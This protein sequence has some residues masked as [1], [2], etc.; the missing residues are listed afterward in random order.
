MAHGS[1][2]LPERAGRVGTFSRFIFIGADLLR[3]F[4]DDTVQELSDRLNLIDFQRLDRGLEIA[5]NILAGAEPQ[6][7]TQSLLAAQDST[8]LLSLY[9]A[10]CTVDY[11]KSPERLSK[12]FNYVFEQVQTRKILRIAD[13]LPAMVRFLFD[14]DIIRLRFARLAW[15]KMPSEQVLTA[16]IFEWV[17][18]SAL[19][20]AIFQVAQP[21][22]HYDHIKRF[23][24]AFLLL[25]DKMDEDLITHSLRGMEI[26]PD[27]YHL[28]LQHLACNS[29]EILQ[30]V[31]ETLRALL[32]KS[33][34]SFWA[35]LGTISLATVAEQIFQS[36]TF[37][38]LLSKITLGDPQSSYILSWAPEFVQS[39]PSV[40]QYD[41]C[42]SLLYHLLER[43]QDRR[44]P[45]NARLACCHA[46]LD[47]LRATLVA[48][49]KSDY[50]INPSTSL[51]VIGDIL[52]LVDKYK[53][54]I[55][56]C[57]DLQN[58][59]PNHLGLK[60]LGMV[61]IRDALALDCKAL[62]AE[63]F[64]L[65]K[66][67][68]IQRGTT[69]HSESIWSAVLDVFRPGN[70]DL[71]KSILAAMSP[72]TGLDKL[73]P[74]DKKKPQHL[75]KSHAQFNQDLHKFSG[76]VSRVFERLSDFKSS[77]LWQLTEDSHAVRPFF[78]SLLSSDQET[79]E[80]AVEVM[81]AM[82]GHISKQEAFSDLLEKSFSPMLNSFTYAVT[83][84]IKTRTF[85]PTPYM[86]KIGRDVLKALTGNTGHLRNHSSLGNVDQNALMAWWLYQWRALDM[87]FS[88]TERWTARV[89]YPTN[90]FQDFCRD[91]ME[92]A[93]ELFDQ[94]EI[95]ASALREQTPTDEEKP[96]RSG[97]SKASMRKVLQVVCNHVN[98]LTMMIRLRDSYLI[99][100][101][102][103]LLGKLLRCLTQFD[104]EIDEFASTYIMDACK[105]ENEPGFRRTNLTRQQK[106]ELQ[107]ALFQHQGV[108]ILE[109]PPPVAKKQATIDA[110]SR[111]GDGKTHE[112]IA[113]I[114]NKGVAFLDNYF[115]SS[116]DK[117]SSGK[118]SSSSSAKSSAGMSNLDAWSKSA[119]SRKHEPKSAVKN[120][121]GGNLIDQQSI[122]D[123]MRA[124][125]AKNQQQSEAFHE[126]RRKD[127]EEKKLR[128]A[129]AIAAA[130][131]LRFPS[132]VQGEGSGM[133]GLGGVAGKDHAPIRSEIMV[134]SDSESDDDL[135]EDETNAL[136]TERKASKRVKEIEESR[137]RAMM[138]QPSG[139]VVK[140]KTART[141]KDLRARLQPN[142]DILYDEIL[143]WDIFH[144]G[145]E[146]PSNNVCRKIADKFSN[147]LS[148]TDTFKP[149]LI[150]EVW[151][152][153]VTAKDEG[154]YKPV[155]IKVLNRLTVDQF[156]E[157]STQMPIVNNRDLNMFERDIVLLS[158]SSD[159]LSNEQEPHCLAV[160][161]RNTRKKDVIEVVYRISKSVN[162][163]MLQCFLPNLKV[164]AI[165]I[166]DMTTTLR[167]FAALSGL[168]FYDLSTEILQAKPS[169]IQKYSDEK[170]SLLSR[171]Y[172]LNPGQAKAI[173]SAN[174]NDGFTLIQG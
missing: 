79:Y 61:V 90:F 97:S 125:Q 19:S 65:D 66:D 45:E 98:G 127:A 81:K 64:A 52:G 130:K 116:E 13:T 5:Q 165:K 118:S 100:V 2:S 59:D 122:L 103:S 94:Y 4:D 17:V 84:I 109:A 80:A 44:F 153:L 167:E 141:K 9:E 78:G 133:K 57:A 92:Y 62:S 157:V 6:Q 47:A 87:V 149:L 106:A 115:K 131:A 96:S 41:G 107:E 53:E 148:Y 117:K 166:A 38:N 101:I 108:E 88:T 112:S 40:H 163:D 95:I 18:H 32:K 1:Q 73:R 105:R 144:Q 10:L 63:F 126:K 150:A 152:N 140:V 70:V 71:A 20:E 160:V 111:S 91:G 170:I 56:G 174:D 113:G 58:D 159:P 23:W 25:L 31:I 146:P 54:M 12:Y 48:F 26:Q 138:R 43:L 11:L 169:P 164:N 50:V 172:T 83:R 145:D 34:K 82:T 36:P 147:E 121:T 30:L 35:A 28:A 135:D 7:R 129:K 102:T 137:K 120:H 168:E 55:V 74:V 85:G 139:P 119:S 24:E 162:P 76:N 29:E 46:G 132:L 134:S 77:E 37:E 3:Q 69:N 51:I 72:L 60:K 154:N 151:R 93:E 86:I 49:V 39:L 124:Q 68:P 156:Y 67:T 161:H 104:M 33:P 75:P 8:A 16:P 114:D 155:E 22:A 173:L 110:W 99:E 89:D 143:R 171:K 142:M 21:S 128:D 27:I 42:R 158:R 136:V 14:D 15:E 123:Q